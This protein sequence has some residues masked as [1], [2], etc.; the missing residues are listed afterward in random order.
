MLYRGEIKKLETRYA[1]GLETH[2]N[3]TYAHAAVILTEY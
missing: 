1:S 2:A 3:L